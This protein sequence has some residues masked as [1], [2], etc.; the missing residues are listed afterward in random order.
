[1]GEVLSFFLGAWN[2]G[3]LIGW[4]AWAWRGRPFH[5]PQLGPGLGRTYSMYNISLADSTI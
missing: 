1:M 4:G 3:D 2:S 5:W